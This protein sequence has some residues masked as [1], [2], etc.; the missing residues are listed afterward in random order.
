MFFGEYKHTRDEKCRMRISAKLKRGLEKDYV[1]TKGTNGCLFV[2]N[3]SYFETEFLEKLSSVPTFNTS[4]QK[5]IR[6]LLSSTYEVEEDSQGRFVLPN[7]LKDFANINKN[8]VL[9]G[10]GKR[11]EIWSEEKWNNYMGDNQNFDDLVKD[12]ELFNV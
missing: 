12:F 4:A 7:S 3:K 8:I 11:I 2:F 5:P 1:I 10:A 9:V 6:A